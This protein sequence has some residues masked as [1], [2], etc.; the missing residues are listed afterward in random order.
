[1]KGWSSWKKM[2]FSGRKTLWVVFG[3]AAV[4]LVY[5]FGVLPLVDAKRKADEEILMKR[6]VIQKYD[7]YL[8]NRKAVEE[9]LE[10]TG[11]Q[12]E[13]IQQK[14]LPGETPQLGAA[15]LQETVK[16]IADKNGIG[17]R[18]FKILEPKEL[19]PFR[20]VSIQIDFNPTNSMLALGQFI[21]DIE[22]HEKGLM[23]S[24]MDLM[25]MN[26]RMPNNIQ[27]NMV[28]SALMKGTKTKEKGREG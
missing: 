13:A 6:R 11:R 24:E 5:F 16:R 15:T 14:L 19:P 20:R 27:G 8:Q 25:V 18:S 23:I 1:M 28:I 2:S 4:V 10:R 12:Y 22:N 21:G 7:E 26:I 17:I 3:G 9:E